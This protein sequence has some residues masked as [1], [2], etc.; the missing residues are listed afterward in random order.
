[1]MFTKV[2]SLFVAVLLLT[3]SSCAHRAAVKAPNN[4]IHAQRFSYVKGDDGRFYIFTNTP[5]DLDEAMKSIRPGPASV[6][7]LDLWVVT[8]LGPGKEEVKH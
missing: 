7:K 3:L 1:M 8:P 5:R 4:V 2:S 6:D